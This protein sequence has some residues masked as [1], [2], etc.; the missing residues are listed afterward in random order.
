V[1]RAAHQALID[2]MTEAEL[3][4]TVTDALTA[5]GY[6]WTHFQAA[7][8]RSGRWLT[9]LTGDPG[10]PDVIALRAGVGWALEFKSQKGRATLGQLGWIAAFRRAG[11]QSYII[12]P[13][14]LDW[15][16]ESLK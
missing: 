6:V 12:R 9:P 5:L 7:R 1:N 10:F 4:K 3:Q 13:D 15:L 8:A 14:E 16:L 2:N 11:F